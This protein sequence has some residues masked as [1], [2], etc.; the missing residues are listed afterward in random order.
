MREG[1]VG[2]EGFAVDVSVIKADAN[3]PVQH[4]VTDASARRALPQLPPVTTSRMPQFGY[5]S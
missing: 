2:G 4:K 1:L 5:R 3:R